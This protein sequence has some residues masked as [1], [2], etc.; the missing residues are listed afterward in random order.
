MTSAIISGN[1]VNYFSPSEKEVPS[2][3]CIE[4]WNLGNN[5]VCLQKKEDQLS[6]EV[7]DK[8]TG[9]SIQ[10]PIDLGSHS[11]SDVITYLLE[12]QPVVLDPG[13][14]SFIRRQPLSYLQR[15][16][17]DDNEICLKKKD[18][19][20]CYEVLNNIT[21]KTM[22][23]PVNLGGIDLT[24]FTMDFIATIIGSKYQPE[25]SEAGEVS[26]S[27]MAS[28][29][30]TWSFRNKEI[31]LLQIESSKLI[32][33]L[34]D[35][36]TNTFSQTPF[37]ESFIHWDKFAEKDHPE[38]RSTR[39]LSFKSRQDHFKDCD[40][41]KIE[42]KPTPRS[43]T[44][45]LGAVYAKQ[46]VGRS[47]LDPSVPIDIKRWAITLINSGKSSGK[48]KIPNPKAWAGHA[49]LIIEGR[50]EGAFFAKKAHFFR[51]INGVPRVSLDDE[52]AKG[53]TFF[54]SQKR[55]TWKVHAKDVMRMLDTVK[56]EI[57]KQ[58]END[59]QVYFDI[60]GSQSSLVKPIRVKKYGSYEELIKETLGPEYLESRKPTKIESNA[61][62]EELMREALEPENLD[63]S[64]APCTPI[65][66]RSITLKDRNGK[67]WTES[68]IQ[69]AAGGI[70]NTSPQRIFIQ[71]SSGN[72]WAEYRIPDN[73][74]TWAI[75]KLEDCGIYLEN[76]TLNRIYASPKKYMVKGR[77]KQ[78]KRVNI[79]WRLQ[80]YKDNQ[81]QDKGVVYTPLM[82]AIVEGNFD[83]VT[84][85]L[86]EG[87][88]P[89]DPK[90]SLDG[91]FNALHA[92]CALGDIRIVKLLL[93]KGMD[94]NK[95]DNGFRF[96][97]LLYTV[98]GCKD[99][100]LAEYLLKKGA[101][102]NQRLDFDFFGRTGH[103]TILHN[104]GEMLTSMAKVFIKYGADVNAKNS[105]GETPLISAV[106]KRKIKMAQ[107]FLQNKAVVDE[108]DENGHTAL[109]HAC[110]L[111]DNENEEKMVHLLIEYGADLEQKRL[112]EVDKKRM[113][114]EA[115]NHSS[116]CVV[117]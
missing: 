89:K 116:N 109:W 31:Q 70:Q 97:P 99:E 74:M 103:E 18:N 12:C 77:G 46:I 69:V 50:D 48:G 25:V 52:K 3:Q 68:N 32:W 80:Q 87:V 98:V 63:S 21:G 7:L 64:L 23:G 36:S 111:S 100:N 43:L 41:E 17:I 19:Q 91:G 101:E 11:V 60:R 22:E 4:R 26:F 55:E 88:D 82:E 51:D 90:E 96:T 42:I 108:K 38:Y 10:G 66:Y 102:V 105:E 47:K 71:D 45:R 73:C 16:I 30:F 59:P 92:A 9:R 67:Q 117:S 94:I 1:S 6:Y 49:A 76:K 75:R 44:Y 33:R 54:Y 27:P 37:S 78:K 83:K 39:D 106:K 113:A 20:L 81:M 72:S 14:V 115:K 79:D 56:W 61:S 112:A 34:F 114:E 65:P 29:S 40:I 15:W 93:K 107:L 5:E 58:K 2:I 28:A 24:N 95:P 86:A 53:E 57:E 85:L 110:M 62:I 84:N 8:I 35:K 13:V 104:T